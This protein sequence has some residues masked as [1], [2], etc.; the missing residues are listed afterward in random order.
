M[1]IFKKCGIIKCIK[2]MIQKFFGGKKMENIEQVIEKKLKKFEN[3]KANERARGFVEE[4]LFKCGYP[5]RDYDLNDEYFIECMTDA[6]E[7]INNC[8]T[9]SDLLTIFLK[10]DYIRINDK[11]EKKR[12]LNALNGDTNHYYVHECSAD[13]Y[14]DDLEKS[15]FDNDAINDIN[16]RL[17]DFEFICIESTGC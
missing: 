4:Y 7:L 5:E 1:T 17:E 8:D 13:D 6:I 11:F 10:E 12:V 16:S 2:K 3:V 15:G 14:I 9:L